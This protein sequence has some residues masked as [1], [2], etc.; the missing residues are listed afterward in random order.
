MLKNISIV[1][2]RRVSFSEIAAAI[3]RA[4]KEAA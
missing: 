4:K 2:A 3:Q 1:G